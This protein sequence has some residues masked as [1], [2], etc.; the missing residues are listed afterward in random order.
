MTV[1][2]IKLYKINSW[3]VI[4]G[5]YYFQMGIQLHYRNSYHNQPTVL[6]SNLKIHNNITASI[7]DIS[8]NY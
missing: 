2:I 7:F 8:K 3:W 5:E 6:K 1:K 4:I